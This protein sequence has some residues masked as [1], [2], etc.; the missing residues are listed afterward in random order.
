MTTPAIRRQFWLLFLILGTSA[1]AA[2]EPAAAQSSL[3]FDAMHVTLSPAPQD[4]QVLAVFH[5][6]NGAR[7]VRILHQELCCGTRFAEQPPA[8]IAAQAEG[9]LAFTIELA[10]HL[11]PFAQVVTFVCDDE[12]QP[13]LI[14]TATI[15]MPVDATVSQPALYWGG[16]GDAFA[17]QRIIV[18]PVPGRR[19]RVKE[20]NES[21]GAFRMNVIHTVPSDP[22]IFEITPMRIPATPDTHVDIMLESGRQLTIPLR[23]A[24]EAADRAGPRP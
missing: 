14:L 8:M 13:V 18:T 21:S 4:T 19:G 23:V 6:R 11:M 22:Y 3:R 15:A 16:R 24:P 12:A 10:N 1:L 2:Q 20:F 5:Y 7:P 17:T 9:T